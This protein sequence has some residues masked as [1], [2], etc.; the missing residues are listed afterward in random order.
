MAVPFFLFIIVAA[1][2]LLPAVSAHCPLC[3][4]GAMLAAGGAAYLG[5]SNG[6][7][8]I[9][10]AMIVNMFLHSAMVQYVISVI[11]VIVYTGLIAWDTQNLKEMYRASNGDEANG[12]MAVMGAL[13][14][15]MNFIMLFQFLLQF[16]GG[17]RN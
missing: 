5:V 10:I 3:T 6:A 4:A 11:G 2:A 7:I 16:M 15:Y 8:G 12:K 13:S 17:N 14:L 1:I 9:F